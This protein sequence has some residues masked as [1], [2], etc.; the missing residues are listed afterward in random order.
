MRSFREYARQ[1]ENTSNPTTQLG[2]RAVEAAIQHSI[3]PSLLSAQENL[4]LQNQVQA[5]QRVTN[6]TLEQLERAERDLAKAT[7]LQANQDLA[8]ASLRALEEQLDA[9]MRTAK[10]EYIINDLAE[11][12]TKAE[13]ELEVLR[14]ERDEGGLKSIA[15]CEAEKARIEEEVDNLAAI[16]EKYNDSYMITREDCVRL[17]EEKEEAHAQRVEDLNADVRNVER[18]RDVLQAKLDA[19]GTTRRISEDAAGEESTEKIK[20]LENKIKKLEGKLAEKKDVPVGFISEVDCEKKN[21]ER[22]EKLEKENKDIK[23]KLEEDLAKLKKENDDLAVVTK[24]GSTGGSGGGASNEALQASN[25]CLQGEVEEANRKAKVAEES[26]AFIARLQS[27]GREENATLT[28]RIADLEKALKAKSTAGEDEEKDRS[29]IQDRESQKL[30]PNK[31]LEDER[32]VLKELD[33]EK[34]RAR[35]IH[36]RQI[37]MDKKMVQEAEDRAERL[38]DR[39]LQS[40]K[41]NKM[42]RDNLNNVRSESRDYR[43]GKNAGKKDGD[44]L[45]GRIGGFDKQVTDLNTIVQAQGDALSKHGISNDFQQLQMLK[46]HNEQLTERNA[47]LVE[48]VKRLESRRV[49]SGYMS[50]DEKDEKIKELINMVNGVNEESRYYYLKVEEIANK[51]NTLVMDKENDVNRRVAIR[52]REKAR[53]QKQKDKNKKMMKKDKARKKKEMIELSEAQANAEAAGAEAKSRINDAK[54]REIEDV[55]ILDRYRQATSQV[56]K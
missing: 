33:E 22:V 41:E 47:K 2:L 17:T 3:E 24:T 35:D 10:E 14:K 28:R 51:Y 12:L 21:K 50:S 40:E 38:E 34:A 11:R 31:K 9:A 16:V 15:V 18:V 32:G 25:E 52:L 6:T 54:R 55:G 4:R 37:E 48:E 56:G 46:Q 43:D 53:E 13:A 44:T 30:A 26:T 45:N 7:E 23:A 29:S 42:L 36:G 27:Q 49:A 5:I 39:I 8:V 19:A 1:P 20:E